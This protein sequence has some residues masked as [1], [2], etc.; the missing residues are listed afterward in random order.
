MW[1]IRNHATTTYF[2]SQITCATPQIVVRRRRLFRLQYN[3]L[4][5]DV[6][7]PKF[8]REINFNFAWQNNTPPA[9]PMYRSSDLVYAVTRRRH[10][11]GHKVWITLTFLHVKLFLVLN[12]ILLNLYFHLFKLQR[13]IS[14]FVIL[15]KINKLGNTKVADK[16]IFPLIIL[17]NIMCSV[18]NK[19]CVS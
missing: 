2:C 16:L 4:L 15:T 3:I 1:Q 9:K 12:T 14:N 6:R 7:L 19:L 17:S 10:S 18:N 13:D 11:T 8:E 5:T